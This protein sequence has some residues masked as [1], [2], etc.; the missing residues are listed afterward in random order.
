MPYQETGA[1][2][3]GMAAIN[4]SGLHASVYL[5]V[6]ANPGENAGMIPVPKPVISG[7]IF[8]TIISDYGVNTD[9]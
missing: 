8:L 1:A 7:L 5:P 3:H 2:A 6:K 4:T 9:G